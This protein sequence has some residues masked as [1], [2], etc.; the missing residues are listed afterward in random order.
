MLDYILQ[1]FVY[2][3]KGVIELDPY[4]LFVVVFSLQ[5]ARVRDPGP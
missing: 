1:T 5:Y 2:A 4:R 3:E